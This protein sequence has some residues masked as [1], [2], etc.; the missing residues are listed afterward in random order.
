MRNSSLEGIAKF[1]HGKQGV[2]T[3]VNLKSQDT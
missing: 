1:K 2:V 3:V